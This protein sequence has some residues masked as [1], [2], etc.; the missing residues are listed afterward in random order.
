M[1]EMLPLAKKMLADHGEFY[2]Y[3]GVLCTDREIVHLGAKE[4]ET[5]MPASRILIEILQRH[6]QEQ[7]TSGAIMASCLVFDVRIRRPGTEDKVDAIQLNLDHR[8][9]YSVEVIFPY[10]VKDGELVLDQP[11]AQAGDGM[12]F[13]RT[14]AEGAALN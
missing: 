8:N 2:P 5:D 6:F 12:V 3:G 7:A 4:S 11:F 1:Q 9:D 10:R 13:A 14:P